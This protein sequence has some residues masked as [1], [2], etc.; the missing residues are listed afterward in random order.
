FVAHEK[1]ENFE[2]SISEFEDRYNAWFKVQIS[3]TKAAVDAV[4]EETV[5]GVVDMEQVFDSF[6]MEEWHAGSYTGEIVFDFKLPEYFE[7]KTDNPYA[8][9]VILREIEEA[10]E[11]EGSAESASSESNE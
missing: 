11:E 5:I 2:E 4:D 9:T 10:D 6:G 7:V 3:G 1:P 8:L